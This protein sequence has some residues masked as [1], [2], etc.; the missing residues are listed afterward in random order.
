MSSGTKHM[1]GMRSSS[2]R[3]SAREGGGGRG[4]AKGIMGRG[5]KGEGVNRRKAYGGRR[6]RGDRMRPRGGKEKEDPL[7]SLT[8]QLCINPPPSSRSLVAFAIT[9]PGNVWGRL[10]VT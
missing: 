8:A 7:E 3:Q 4:S 2:R 1:K 10:K 5:K 6:R 9:C